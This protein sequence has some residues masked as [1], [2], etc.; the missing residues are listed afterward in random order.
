MKLRPSARSESKAGNAANAG[1]VANAMA[2][3][4]EEAVTGIVRATNVRQ[5]TR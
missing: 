1:N 4:A 3:G 5:P 2:A